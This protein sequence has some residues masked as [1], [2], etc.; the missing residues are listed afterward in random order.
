MKFLEIK[1]QL[2]KA[3]EL[4]K[5][6]THTTAFTGAGI[7]VES[8]IPPFR[9]KNGLWNTIDP[10]FLDTHY[11]VEHPDESWRL[12]KSIFYEFFEKAKPNGAHYA[13][14]ELER[15]GLLDVTITQNIDYLHQQAGSHNV[16]EFH[17]SSQ[18]FV[19]MTCGRQMKFNEEL[20]S[21]LPPKCQSCSGLLKPNFVFFGEPIPEQANSR[22]L[23]E[24]EI[25]DVFIVIGTTGEILPA[26]LIPGL[27]KNH[28][29]AIIEINIEPSNFTQ[30]ITD[31][32]L[33]GKAT[34]ILVKLLNI[35]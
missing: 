7:S 35:I 4:L 9:G 30:N 23:H 14:A 1:D 17:G 5:K 25:A 3:V 12:I 13:L 19:C 27:A 6:S 34:D 18:E 15:K 10:V 26:S 11:F 20:L 33:Q 31:I 2:H 16:V 21:S 28:G 24:A 8:G 32:F 29:A 22:S